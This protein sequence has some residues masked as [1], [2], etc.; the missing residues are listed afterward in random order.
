[1]Q[2]NNIDGQ[3][4]VNDQTQNVINT[5][6]V[7][8]N[9]LPEQVT[10][11]VA[12]V[13][14]APEP[15]VMPVQ[16]SSSNVVAPP[17]FN[18]VQP[19]SSIPVNE[20]VIDH[21]T[22]LDSQ[23]I[24][25]SSP[26]PIG[27]GNNGKKIKIILIALTAVAVLIGGFFAIKYFFLDNSKSAIENKALGLLFAQDKPIPI[28]KDGLYGFIDTNGKML[29]EPKYTSIVDGFHGD[30]AVVSKK[31]EDNDASFY[32]SNTYNV[33][34][35][36]GQEKAQSDY[37]SG[38]EFIDEYSVWI[39]N[40]RLYDEKLNP[41]TAED[42]KVDYVDSGYI[43][44]TKAAD[45]T[46]G[47]MNLRGDIKY[48]S[49][50][51]E[52]G[53]F[54]SADLNDRDD[55]IKEVYGTLT[56]YESNEAIVNFE[57]GKVVYDFGQK[58]VIAEDDNIFKLYDNDLSDDDQYI[59]VA[60]DKIVFQTDK[61]KTA[62]LEFYSAKDQILE[63]SYRYGRDKK[64]YD[65]KNDQILDKAPDRSSSSDD[66]QDLIELEY[67]YKEMNCSGKKG[68]IKGEEIILSCDYDSILFLNSDVF[69]YVKNKTGKEIV[70][71]KNNDNQ[72][73]IDLRSKAVLKTF[74][75]G[76]VNNGR[77]SIF[78]SNDWYTG[79]DTITVY[80]MINNKSAEFDKD[81]GI[82]Y[83]TNY[84]I[85]KKDDKKSYYNSDLKK[86]YEADQ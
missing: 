43:S 78:I 74:N 60:K 23:P 56:L 52:G 5:V 37:G 69:K 79:N 75:N 55:N 80:N 32:F 45:N 39:I 18:Q 24:I 46:F 27:S 36:S 12:E 53:M 42:V 4:Q 41:I 66:I 38:I 28:E 85:V 76:G 82:E 26:K 8:E 6:P 7:A 49:T 62:G 40:S 73:V 84:F 25:G 61:N 10:V 1:M 34:D 72:S 77:S 48:V 64:Y 51:P 63:V 33:I 2:E 19:V 14:T 67:G 9:S 21:A 13:A 44:F 83:Y 17:Y 29:I 3:G 47:I 54:L 59:Y 35:K 16:D 11:P 22:R 15:V 86:I 65:I 68:I 57:T 81:S 31:N 20:P 58:D 70:I 30:F 71:A 50:V